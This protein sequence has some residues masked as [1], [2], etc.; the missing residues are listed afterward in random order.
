MIGEGTAKTS[1]HIGIGATGEDLVGTTADGTNRST[2]TLIAGASTGLKS[3]RVEFRSQ[4]RLAEFWVNGKKRGE[5][6][7]N[8]P[9]ANDANDG[10]AMW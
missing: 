10:R 8:L 2:T 9:E 5:I 3:G 4:P 6:A 7:T 1:R